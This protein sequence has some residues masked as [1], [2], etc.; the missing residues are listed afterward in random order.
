MQTYSTYGIALPGKVY[1]P[2]LETS[3][4]SGGTAT[5]TF[6]GRDALAYGV[7]NIVPYC[8][9]PNDVTF[10]VS[11]E[12]QDKV[13]FRNISTQTLIDH[14]R[15]GSF[16]A[17]VIIPKKRNLVV[18]LANGGGADAT[19]NVLLQ[20]LVEP[21][22]AI[23]QAMQRKQ[24]G[25]IPEC[26]FAYGDLETDDGD[27]FEPVGL[28]LPPGDWVFDR[29]LVG[30]RDNS[31]ANRDGNTVR[32]RSGDYTVKQPA[33]IEQYRDQFGYGS[34]EGSHYTLMD[35]DPFDAEVSNSS[36]NTNTTDILIPLVPQQVLRAHNDVM[37]SLQQSV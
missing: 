10:T 24:F 1:S 31:A 33:R 8:E 20:G 4:P 22:L 11:L 9:A 12:D 26:R 28:T 14:A 34:T 5:L 35:F 25:F 13:L 17:P 16:P 15:N 29:V 32:L 36:G 6:R 37:R 23:V 7:T 3:V 27:V 19:V 21:Q 18:E 2:A 30:V